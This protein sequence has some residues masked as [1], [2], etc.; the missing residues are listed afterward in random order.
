[1]KEF[2]AK[3][4]KDQLVKWIRDWFEVNGKD[5]TA[6]IGISGGKDSTIV[7][8]LCAEALGKDR[9]LG[10][11]MPCGVQNDIADSIKVC[12]VLG[13]PNVTVNIFNTRNSIYHEI[14][15]SLNI[16]DNAI[17]N[18][19][20]RLRMTTLY[21]IAQS[22]HGRVVN[23]S[24]LSEYTLGYFTK[25]GDEC[26]DFKP[27]INLTCSEV[28]A[29]GDELKDI[30]S[31]LIHKAPDDGLPNSH[32]DEEKFGFSYEALDKYIRKGTSGDD[33][34]DEKI[35]KK[36][37]SVDFKHHPVNCFEWE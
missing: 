5:C 8:G 31:Y 11:M 33:E 36:I 19:N 4:V 29:I 37:A 16:S 34:I 2:N 22:V 1:M 21:T 18:I 32:P 6:V 20:P 7:A 13:I 27:L 10:V 15:K 14:S 26:G 28:V 9:V 17:T 35:S 12:E 24:N 25:F 30:P 23:T 3:E